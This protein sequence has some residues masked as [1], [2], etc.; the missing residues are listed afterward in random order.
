[1]TDR[2]TIVG[3]TLLDIDVEGPATRLAADSGAPVVDEERVEQRPGGAGLAAILAARD[4]WPVTL[5][6]ALSRDPGGDT[7]R[8][9][10]ETAGV[11]V[12]DLGLAGPTPQKMRIRTAGMTHVRLDRGGADAPI[13][14]RIARELEMEGTVLV[15]DY[16]RGV[17]SADPVRRDLAHAR[18]IVWD[19]HP[20]GAL[21]PDLVTV[22]TPNEAEVAAASGLD[23]RHGSH[24]LRR[25]RE[26]WRVQ[27]CCMTRGARGALLIDSPGPPIAFP[28]PS[29][30]VRDACGAGDRFAVSMVTG[31]A[32]GLPLRQA[33]AN[34]V[35]VASAYVAGGATTDDGLARALAV[36]QSVRASGGTVVATG[37]CFDLLHPGHL[38]TLRCARQ[39]GDCLIVCLNSD[40]SARGIK[41]GNRPASPAR[42]RAA[43]LA[44]LNCVDAVVTFDDQT[45]ERLLA[46]LRPSIWVKGADYEHEPLPEALAIAAW[47]G[48]IVL[49]HYLPGYS[50]TAKLALLCGGE[51]HAGPPVSSRQA[52]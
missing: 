12:V 32:Q 33:V 46:A 18:T 17:A 15:S 3:D 13:G 19:P 45:P 42:D 47:G 49:S 9:A 28:A 34:A 22:I 1:M 30:E 2:L 26:L 20:L 48:E 31:L 25:A 29:I 38:E 40:V 52:G 37:G 51:R 23:P 43:I 21:P 35:Y 4:G 16:G 6:T 7:L 44:N 10:F 8:A 11:T 27:A 5:V 24:A 39:L 36:S 41:G 50:T 14:T